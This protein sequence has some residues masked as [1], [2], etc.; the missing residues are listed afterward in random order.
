MALKDWKS[1]K[2]KA[3]PKELTEY[4][5]LIIFQF[6]NSK[7]RVVISCI[8]IK[9]LGY[10]VII[11]TNPDC[12]EFSKLISENFFKTKSAALKYAKEYMK[13]H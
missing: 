1:I 7:I 5:N 9:G 8:L 10:R 13:K 3:F 2:P 4:G 6:Y 12:F 11:K